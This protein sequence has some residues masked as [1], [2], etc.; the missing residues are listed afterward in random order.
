MYA[1]ELIA[2]STTV[3]TGTRD[4]LKVTHLHVH[5]NTVIQSPLVR[6]YKETATPEMK[7]PRVSRLL[8]KERVR[9]LLEAVYRAQQRDGRS[10]KHD[11]A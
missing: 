4:R 1:T 6:R 11:Q 5:S 2:R 7:H 9:D 3:S 10:T 8:G